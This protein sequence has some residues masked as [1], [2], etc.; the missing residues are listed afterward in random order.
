MPRKPKNAEIT[1]ATL[2][3]TTPADPVMPQPASPRKPRAPKA[4]APAEA[5]TKASTGKTKKPVAPVAAAADPASVQPTTEQVAYEAY[6]LWLGEGRPEGK[7]MEHWLVAEQIV[8]SRL[9]LLSAA[10]HTA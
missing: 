1:V 7:D 9:S 3:E 2:V 6:L 8:R 5:A 4:K 10:V